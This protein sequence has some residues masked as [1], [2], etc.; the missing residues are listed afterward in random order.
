ML[1]I[2]AID[3]ARLGKLLG[4]VEKYQPAGTT[5]NDEISDADAA[6]LKKELI[7]IMRLTANMGMQTSAGIVHTIL[8]EWDKKLAI[9]P[10]APMGRG[11][12][13]RV[14][15]ERFDVIARVVKQ[16]LQERWLL[17]LTE[18]RERFFW[19]EHPFGD[20]VTASFPSAV[21]DIREADMC[22]ALERHTG[23]V[24]HVMRAAEIA[25]RVLAW[26]RR[27]EIIGKGGKPDPTPLELR[28]WDQILKGLDKAIEGI[29]QMPNTQAREAQLQFYNGAMTELRAFKV[30]FRHRTMHARENYDGYQ[31]GS[32]VLHVQDFMQGLARVVSENKRTP[33]IWTKRELALYRA[34]SVPVASVVSSSGVLISGLGRPAASAPASSQTG[35]TGAAPTQAP[36]P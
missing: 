30:L 8:E 29:E 9:T 33:I 22:F 25:L 12:T 31:A 36:G 5:E 4:D 2:Y 18:G 28:Q 17:R 34:S 20:R 21:Y 11:L 7:S 16:E 27:I 26:D 10:P 19:R 6:Y 14:M 32:A 13:Y 35:T 23:V 15:K 24:F 1:Q 3:F